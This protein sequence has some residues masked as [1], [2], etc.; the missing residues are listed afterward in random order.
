MSQSSDIEEFV[1]VLAAGL[2]YSVPS[3]TSHLR[4]VEVMPVAASPDTVGTITCDMMAT[5]GAGE[6]IDAR[7]YFPIQAKFKT[8]TS[9]VGFTAVRIGLAVSD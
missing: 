7:A 2:P 8:V 6:T 9:V 4:I 1:T 5:T 3:S